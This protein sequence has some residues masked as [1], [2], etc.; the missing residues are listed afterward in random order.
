[1]DY[2]DFFKNAPPTIPVVSI[3][4]STDPPGST[5]ANPKI[6]HISKDLLDLVKSRFPDKM[7][8]YY[9][10]EDNEEILQETLLDMGRI[11]VVDFL[12]V[13]LTK[14]NSNSI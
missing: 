13:L 7:R 4:E 6:P 11:E 10:N 1:M 2:K 5:I 8:R 3:K 14:Q 9:S 12:E